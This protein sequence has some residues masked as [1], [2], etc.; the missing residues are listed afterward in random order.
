MKKNTLF[1]LLALLWG[2]LALAQTPTITSFN[3]KRGGVGTTITITGNNFNTT[4]SS[5]IIS[6]GAV[7]SPALT[8]TATTLTVKVPAGASYKPVSVNVNGLT[9][10]TR[11]TFL[12]TFAGTGIIDNTTLADNVDFPLP[13]FGR[14][15]AEVDDVDGDGKPD[16][17]AKGAGYISF[18]RNTSTPGVINAS[19]FAPRY[20]VAL[21]IAESTLHDF[22][23]SDVDNDSKKDLVCIYST[24]TGGGAAT[25]GPVLTVYLRLFR[26]TS[27]SGTISF[28]SGVDKFLNSYNSV[29]TG[30]PNSWYPTYINRTDIESAD[31]N[32]DGKT[33]LSFTFTTQRNTTFGG[34]T[35]L[36]QNNYS[37]SITSTT[38]SPV[39]LVGGGNETTL[40]NI[41]TDNK[42]EICL[43]G[44]SVGSGIAYRNI[45]STGGALAFSSSVAI[46]GENKLHLVD[47]DLDS[48]NDLYYQSS[49]RQ[50]NVTGFIIDATAFG[51]P[52]TVGAGYLESGFCD[53]NGDGTVDI[54]S[55]NNSNA[56]IGLIPNIHTSGVLSTSSFG[57]TNDFQT[58]GGGPVA[59]SCND[60]DLD[61]KPELLFINSG[62][63]LSVMR[64][65]T[66]SSGSILTIGSLS[67]GMGS[68]AIVPITANT[69]NGVEGFQF[70][71][72]YDPNKL[73]YVNCSNW[74]TGIDA[75]NVLITDNP[76]TGKLSF[77]Y[78]DL[79]FSIANGTFF[80]IN[81]NVIASLAGSTPITWSDSPT[82]REFINAIPN[83]LNVTYNN[84]TVNVVNMLYSVSGTISYDNGTNTAIGSTT[85]NLLDNNNNII[86][87]TT[88]SGSGQYTFTGLANANYTVRPVTIKPWG[89]ATSLDITLYKKHIGNVPGFT[90]TGI[91]LGSG[92]VN[93]ST[94]LTS[95]DLTLI[96]KRIGAQISSF[97][98]GDWLF[99][100]GEITI[101]GASLI[102]NIKAICYG[103]VNGS[104]IPQ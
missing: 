41:N 56:I 33:D 52:F 42:P 61:G 77:I 70:T 85:V 19:S 102:K 80:N 53:I 86:A 83:I 29:T 59:I 4:P 95:I 46:G 54:C 6:F 9:A 44:T 92:D 78:N 48:K 81:F 74:A 55:G 11:E 87:T 25:G 73:R 13:S 82:P 14:N 88:T 76:S 39:Y 93:L 96:K 68:T 51:T 57:A 50:N 91:K 18:F 97:T 84:G 12:P 26:N 43:S 10:W 65:Q 15:K 22:T 30:N 1:L 17:A 49:V 20:D 27:T 2:L 8:A 31:L 28:A 99:E 32:L 40:S 63:F 89:G 23:L 58:F 64:N 71:I 35:F 103:D 79:A 100:S 36:L 47:F 94:T 3:P 101:N 62:G 37:S 104:N 7:K 90:L 72:S 21:V 38:F 34:N 16:V 60:I 24:S 75:A 5:N 45:S 66:P 98:S 69:L 67:A